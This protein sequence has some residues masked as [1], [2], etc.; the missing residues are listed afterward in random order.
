MPELVVLPAVGDAAFVDELRRAWDRGAAVLPVDPRLPAGAADGL[1]ATAAARAGALAAG[2]ALVIATSGS[3]GAPK[4]VVHTH[5]GLAAHAA[6][7]H[8][9]LAVDPARDRWFACLP[10]AHLGGLG[11]VVR[12]IV[13]E[14]P[15][16]VAP[17]P[18]PDALAAALGSGATLTSLVPTALDRLDPVG[19]RWIVLGGAADPTTRPANVVRTYGSTETGGGVVYDGIPLDGV[20]VRIEPDGAIALHTP[21]L[22]RGLLVDDAAL[23]PVGPEVDGWLRTGDLGRW[24]GERLVVDGRADDLIVTGG[25]NVWPAPVEDRL[26]SHPA[27]ADA[28]VVGV[29]DPEWGRRVVALVAVAAGHELPT[30]AELRDHVRAELPAHAAPR[31]V[32]RVDA[33]PRTA[34]GKL[35]RAD[36]L[37]I[38]A[39]DRAG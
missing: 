4:L 13:D 30:L 23:I 39:A 26:R 12:T 29:A 6:A 10:L 25:E 16:A 33:L 31:Q 22:A 2:D 11:V 35:R 28:A 27:I 21:T 20:A 17:R 15:L 19:W 38:A 37:A 24:D 9:R 3:T 8:R 1:R 7:V 5:A 14:V 36:A 34:L 18:D 32:L